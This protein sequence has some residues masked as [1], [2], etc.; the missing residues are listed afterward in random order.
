V[1]KVGQYGAQ[2]LVQRRGAGDPWR[3]HGED[4]DNW[5]DEVVLTALA[6]QSDSIR[7]TVSGI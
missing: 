7:E 1:R 6:R 2:Q 3:S 5:P 4:M